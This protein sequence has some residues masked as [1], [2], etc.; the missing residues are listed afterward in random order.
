MWIDGAVRPRN[1][2]P[3]AW[4]VILHYL[5]GMDADTLELVAE[6]VWS[7][8]I[9]EYMES[10]GQLIQT[11][12]HRAEMIAAISGLERML[13]CPLDIVIYT[14]SKYLVSG[15]QAL[16]KWK[17]FDWI[18]MSNYPGR[19]SKP[20]RPVQ[21]KDLWVKLDQFNQ[22]H[23]IDWIKTTHQDDNNRRADRIAY[24]LAGQQKGK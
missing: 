10:N 15:I 18:V 9:P 19:G 3:G 21:N 23:H 17:A 20:W 5:R 2:G 4:A 13:R 12:S 11:T 22:M 16:P 24:E 6:R 1:P 14:D 8:P 7:G